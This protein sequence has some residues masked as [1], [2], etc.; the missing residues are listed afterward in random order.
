MLVLHLFVIVICINILDDNVN[1]DTENN[2]SKAGSNSTEPSKRKAHTGVVF[3]LFGAYL[4][5]P[6]TKIYKIII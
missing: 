6:V 2:S 3:I 5:L 1:S 4:M